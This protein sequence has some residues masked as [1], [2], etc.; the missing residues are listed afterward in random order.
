MACIA[1]AYP[2]PTVRSDETLERMVV[3]A[4]IEQDIPPAA[5]GQMGCDFVQHRFDQAGKGGEGQP[6]QASLRSLPIEP[7][8][9]FALDIEPPGESELHRPELQMER[10]MRRA[11]GEVAFLPALGDV[12]VMETD[13]FQRLGGDILATQRIVDAQEEQAPAA[14]FLDLSDRLQEET[15]HRLAHLGSRPGSGSK[16]VGEGEFVGMGQTE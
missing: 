9:D 2:L 13:R 3:V 16:E 12:I 15:G 1:T 4:G 5:L 11:V 10:D 6:G 7:G 14:P 8:H